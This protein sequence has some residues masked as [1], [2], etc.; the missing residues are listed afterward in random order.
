MLERTDMPNLPMY[1]AV[2]ALQAS[3]TEVVRLLWA[4]N[5]EV[6]LIAACHKEA[7][8]E[9]LALNEGDKPDTT[10]REE[11]Q[12]RADRQQP[13]APEGTVQA[14]FWVSGLVGRNKKSD[15]PGVGA[16]SRRPQA[17]RALA[18]TVQ[19]S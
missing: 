3:I 10:S 18:G 19:V 13:D 7:A 1:T 6:P 11:A 4:E 5:R 15:W 9:L 8:G 17:A 12:R 16:A 14:S 2:V